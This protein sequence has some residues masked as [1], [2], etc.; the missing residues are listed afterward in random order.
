[1]DK[2]KELLSRLYKLREELKEKTRHLEGRASIICTDD[3]L[4][5]IVKYKPRRVVDFEKIKG[6]GKAFI[7]NY[8]SDF[9]NVILSFDP[10]SSKKKAMSKNVINTMKELEKKLVNINKKNR[11]L[12]LNKISKRFTYD[13]S[14][15][16]DRLLQRVLFG[17][18]NVIICDEQS[19]INN[20]KLDEE[21]KKKLN[22]VSIIR[23]VNIDYP[24]V[25]GKL[26]G[27]DFEVHAPLALFPVVE[28]RTPTRIEISLDDTRD[29][30]YNNTLILAYYKF[31]NI[32]EPLT[33][34]EIEINNKED[35]FNDIVSYYK[36]KGLNIVIDSYDLE[37]FTEYKNHTFPKFDKG[38]LH[39]IP[40][41]ILGVFPICSSSIQ[42][43]FDDMIEQGVSSK[44]VDD[45]LESNIDND[46]YSDNKKHII[47]VKEENINYINE[48]NSSQEKV[49][50]AIDNI[51]EL[52]VEGPP[53]TG[54][55][56]TIV[57]LIADAVLENKTVLMVSEKK[58]AL[59]VVY[60]RLGDL[61]KYA[62]LID[63]VNNKHVFYNQMRRIIDNLN[64]NKNEAIITDDL[65]KKIDD[66]VEK[67][68]YIAKKLYDDT[69][70]GIKQYK[71]YLLTEKYDPTNKDDVL[72]YSFIKKAWT[73]KN[74]LL[75]SKFNVI[76]NAKELFKDGS[77]LEKV[78]KYLHV[79]SKYN[80]IKYVVPNLTT[81]DVLE[82]KAKLD[83]NI[84]KI[85]EYKNKFFL[86]RLFHYF[87]I[88]KYI[89]D[90]LL[91]YFNIEKKELI[92][93]IKRDA[94]LVMESLDYYND[95][96]EG[97]LLFDKLNKVEK[98]YVILTHEVMN[99]LNI[100]ASRANDE[101]FNALLYRQVEMFELLNKDV[102][103]NISDYK[104]V[105]KKICRL[106]KNKIAIT[107]EKLEVL[108][109]NKMGLIKA[110]KYYN[111]FKRATDSKRSISVNRFI[112]KFGFELFNS[113]KIWLLTP[114][115]VSDI[116]PLEP[117]LFDLLIFDEA[118]QMY[119][120][121]GIPSIYRA[122]KVVVAG[123]TKQLRPSS[124]GFG[125]TDID[126][127]EYDEDEVI[128]A[129]L[130]EESLLDLARYK[131]QDV[132]LNFHYRS[133]YEELIAFSN[134][135]FYGGKLYVSPNIVN[136]SLP[137]IEVHK[138][139]DG[140]W[141]SRSNYKEARYIV[142]LLN[143]IFK[144]R[145]NNETIGII[146]F[147]SSQ[148]NLILDLID[149]ESQ[150]NEEFGNYV[151]KEVI[152]K[153][154]GED[155]GLF[156]KNI[157]TVQ[158]DER[159]IIIF[160]ISYSKNEQDKVQAKFGW[161]N[162]LA[163]ENRLNVAISRAKEKIHIVTSIYP[164]EL[165][166][167]SSKHRGPKLFKKYLEYAYAISDK[168]NEQA[169]DILLSL[170]DS[171]NKTN[172]TYNNDILI[173]EIYNNLVK[174]GIDVIKNVGIGGYQIDLAI[175]K[176]EKYVLGIECDGPLF[177]QFTSSRERDIHRQK[178]L[179]Q[180]GW[181]MYRVWS[182]NWWNNKENEIKNIINNIK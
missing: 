167:E 56:Q 122:K 55:S 130:E 50:C 29:I 146:T 25:I 132:L 145:K 70:F 131:Y 175:K 179:E 38:E 162:Q 37:K 102:L 153:K 6:I 96:Y 144:E 143:Q 65:S 120:E 40:C 14:E 139:P 41:A 113:V 33:Y 59:D 90:S 34:D 101:V 142:D 156:V 98:E 110:S 174:L 160:S 32:K 42:K 18:C 13:M 81:F 95:Y 99:Y 77:L 137:P 149:K 63:D 173:D 115:V 84:T 106:I 116:L 62:L 1:M 36:Y 10:E 85:S 60:S 168:N 45:L 66:E 176:D 182:S 24:F 94:H 39:L 67:L 93:L 68:D 103:H 8:A 169:K 123:D 4:V 138:I 150:N 91:S 129:A 23:E 61:S 111:D 157:E 79:F 163:G 92:K 49:L 75:T 128:E 26:S 140:L 172:T 5:E 180:R 161:L 134:Y 86:V 48:L 87:K 9:L 31:N 159:D 76:N 22:L 119:V 57:S 152:R 155:I 27:E 46:N 88:N 51:D 127:D 30:V 100:D 109:L 178:Y 7:E 11:L 126:L 17:N 148:R 181:K 166:V 28:K 104:E 3:A 154:D 73:N 15:L 89:K 124:L 64:K 117:G 133:K 43:D 136:S 2:N 20:I 52:V 83:D 112:N 97:K 74:E 16:G 158:G 72:K 164:F 165:N 171:V 19:P 151:A 118:S 44:L 125:R 135:A 107:K 21:I 71:L 121:K 147:N 12:S 141:V 82:L 170:S 108:L 47:D 53:G 69:S 54:K 114:E 35:L 105:T 80:I 78:I 58:T 177:D